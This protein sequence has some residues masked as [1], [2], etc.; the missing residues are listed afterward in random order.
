MARV[1]ETGQEPSDK[2]L[3]TPSQDDSPHDPPQPAPPE[4]EFAEHI[5]PEEPTDDE[6]DP[7]PHP[8]HP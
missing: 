5:T 2:D 3:F 7:Q 8:R 1:A 6:H 4:D